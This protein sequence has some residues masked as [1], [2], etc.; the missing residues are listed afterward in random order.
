MD[1]KQSFNKKDVQIRFTMREDFKEMIEKSKEKVKY[2]LKRLKS[3]IGN[4][5]NDCIYHF[6]DVFRENIYIVVVIVDFVIVQKI[7]HQF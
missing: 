2:L 4:S 5:I 7:Q 3:C 1:N 6:F